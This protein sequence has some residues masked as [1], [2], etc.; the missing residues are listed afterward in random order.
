MVTENFKPCSL[1]VMSP[2]FQ[3]KHHCIH[4]SRPWPKFGQIYRS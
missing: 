2:Y 1:Q 4:R 3:H